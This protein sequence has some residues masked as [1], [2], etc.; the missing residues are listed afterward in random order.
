MMGLICT[1]KSRGFTAALTIFIKAFLR[2]QILRDKRRS[3]DRS[4]SSL[5]RACR[6]TAV[7]T[8][9]CPSKITWKLLQWLLLQQQS[10]QPWGC[11]LHRS[12]PSSLHAEIEEATFNYKYLKY[13]RI[14]H[15]IW[16]CSF[17]HYTPTLCKL[18]STF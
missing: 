5:L 6:K 18:S 8:E 16:M 9:I 1:E 11:Y 2:W 10:Y 7:S 13:L 3:Y 14:K 15:I 17:I 12:S 4:N